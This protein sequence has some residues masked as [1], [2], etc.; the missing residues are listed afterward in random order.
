MEYKSPRLAA[1]AIIVDNARLLLVNAYPPS[2]GSDLWCA[3]G[4]GVEIGQSVP[5]N[6]KRE[7]F[8]ETGLEISVGELALVSEFHRPEVGFHQVELFFRCHV[9]SG[10]LSAEWQDPARVVNAR[11][12]F[13]WQDLQ[14]ARFKPDA[15]SEVAFGAAGPV[16]IEPLEHQIA[17]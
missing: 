15:L 14:M 10:S 8:E 3:P 6:L 11:R 7:V 13:T 1:R 5:E 12:F 17:P 2:F 9:T 4:G 16:R